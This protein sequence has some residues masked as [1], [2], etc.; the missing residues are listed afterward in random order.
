MPAATNATNRK[1]ILITGCSTGIGKR[2]AE[3]L[4]QGGWQVFATA[5]RDEDIA[6]LS[7]DIGVTGLYL[8]YQ[9]SA[10]IKAT[11]EQVLAQTDGHLF[12]LFNNGGFGQPGAVEDLDT[13]VLRAQF[14]TNFFGWHDLTRRVIPA[15]RAQGGGRIIQ[16]S[17]VF[18]FVSAHYRGA[19]TASKHALE[20]LSDAMRQELR[21]TNIHISIIEPGPIRTAFNKRALQSYRDNINMQA[22]PH[23]DKY[24]QRVDDLENG[25]DS[26]FKLEPD[27][28]VAKLQHALTSK[29]PK[30]RYYV[31]VP[32]Y[33]L[34]Y[35]KRL[36]PTKLIDEILIRN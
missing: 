25:G 5:R 26:T 33:V 15:M 9:D 27:A 36:L 28:V 21:G 20:A 8:D 35:A 7:D 10:S 31:T 11:A 19:Y 29:N 4:H 6:M 18:G 24:Q 23:K 1:S 3:I 2:A 22:S 16:C 32:T 12:A 17:S 14:E 30:S 34:A 13:D